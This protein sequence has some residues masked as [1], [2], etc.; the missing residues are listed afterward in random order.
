M[1]PRRALVHQGQDSAVAGYP[2]AQGG[3]DGPDDGVDVVVRRG[4]VLGDDGFVVGDP[5]AQ[6]VHARNGC[7]KQASVGPAEERERRPQGRPQ[8]GGV[9]L[10]EQ[11]APEPD[12]ELG[13]DLARRWVPPGPGSAD[14]G[15]DVVAGVLGRVS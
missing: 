3:V 7:L 5:V 9:P 15:G 14:R 11:V 13:D 10:G 12:A 4:Q 8:R 2:G 1:R 6:S